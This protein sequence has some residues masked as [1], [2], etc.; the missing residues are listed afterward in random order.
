MVGRVP[1]KTTRFATE[2]EIPTHT[3]A[4]Q[5]GKADAPAT[6]NR[7]ERT[8]NRTVLRQRFQLESSKKHGGQTPKLMNRSKAIQTTASPSKKTKIDNKT[9]IESL[10]LLRPERVEEA[11]KLHADISSLADRARASRYLEIFSTCEFPEFHHFPETTSNGYFDRTHLENSLPKS[12]ERSLEKASSAWNKHQ[13][14]H[15][16]SRVIKGDFRREILDHAKNWE[17]A[18]SPE[19]LKFAE[20]AQ[21]YLEQ[22]DHLIGDLSEIALE[23]TS[24]RFLRSA[25]DGSRTEILKLAADY[26]ALLKAVTEEKGP[27]QESRQLAL[28][29][30]QE[31][32]NAE[33]ARASQ[34]TQAGNPPSARTGGSVV[35]KGQVDLNS[36]ATSND[37]R[38]LL[39]IGNRRR[40]EPS[41][42]SKK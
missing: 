22:T 21:T 19:A 12:K 34:T 14:H 31:Q 8:A 16:F 27:F 36:S 37:A 11:G 42:L 6:A 32:A 1:P 33:F 40:H 13:P 9:K 4:K 18:G 17:A 7:P 29:L 23:L 3:D 38:D 39:T 35:E 20:H 30:A 25:P 28:R 15:P 5:S 2:G 10:K 24:D 41:N 26:K